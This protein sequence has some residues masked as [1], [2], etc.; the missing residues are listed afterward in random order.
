MGIKQN[1]DKACVSKDM[2]LDN[3]DKGVHSVLEIHLLLFITFCWS[4]DIL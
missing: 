4:S 2:N 3:K 1:N